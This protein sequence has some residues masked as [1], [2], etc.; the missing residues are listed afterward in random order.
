[1]PENVSEMSCLEISCGTGRIS[2]AIH[3]LVKK[4]TVSDI[5]EKPTKETG[6]RPGVNWPAQNACHLKLADQTFDLIFSS[7]CIEH[8]PE[9]IKAVVEMTRVLKDDGSLIVTLPN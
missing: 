3:P 6:E 4:L 8:T 1:V 9:P 5:S 2:E 7:E